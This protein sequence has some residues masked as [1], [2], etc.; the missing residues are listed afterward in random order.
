MTPEQRHAHKRLLASLPVRTYEPKVD[1]RER[2]T[3]KLVT[4]E[5]IAKMRQLE[6]EGMSRFEIAIQC[7]VA[8]ATVTRRL[9]KSRK[10]KRIA[11]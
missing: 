4:P 2:K 6:A 10:C 5:L 9:G 3:H 1:E 8:G 7:G 11:R